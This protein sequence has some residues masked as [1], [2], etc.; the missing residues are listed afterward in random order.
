MPKIVVSYRREDSEAIAGRIRDRLVGHYSPESVFMDIDSIPYGVDFREQIQ[1]ALRS[2]DIL[3]AVIGPK[4]TGAARGRRARIREESDPVRI[5][6]ERALESGITLVPILVNGAKMPKAAD[7]PDSLRD[8]SYRNAA[9][10]DAG[11]D[12]HQHVDRLIRSMDQILAV[13]PASGSASTAL[14]AQISPAPAAVVNTVL[15]SDSGNRSA[16]SPKPAAETAPE[17]RVGDEATAVGGPHEGETVAADIIITSR[18]IRAPRRWVMALAI[19]AAICMPLLGGGYFYL[20]SVDLKWPMASPTSEPPKGPGSPL[21]VAAIDTSCKPNGAAAFYDDFKTPEGGWGQ[22]SEANFFKDGRMVLQPKINEFEKWIYFPLLFKDAVICSEVIS[23]SEIKNPDQDVAGGIIFWA[24]DIGNYYVAEIHAN[25]SYSIWRRVS[26]K[27]VSVVPRT[28]APEL[29]EGPNAVNQLKVST[30]RNRAALFANGTKLV[31]FWGQPP[32]RGGAVGLFGQSEK[33]A[34]N[35]WKFSSISVTEGTKESLPSAR[36]LYSAET[37]SFLSACKENGTA[38]FFDDFSSPDPGWGAS[39]DNRT[40]KDGRMLLK[41]SAKSFASWIFL[42]MIFKSGIVCADIKSPAQI[43]NLGSFSEGGVIFWASD[44]NNYYLA[45]LFPDATFKVSRRIDGRWATVL[46]RAQA[47][48][49]QSGE[50]AVN[51]LKITFGNDSAILTVNSSEVAELRRAQPPELGGA[52]GL[53]G[54]SEEEIENEWSFHNIAVMENNQPP[55]ASAQSTSSASDANP[56]KSAAPAAFFDNFTAPDPGWGPSSTSAYFDSGQMVL[57]PKPNSSQ[58]WIYSPMVFQNATICSQ[59][60][61]PTK[62]NKSDDLAAGGL[63]FWAED[64]DNYYQAKIFT[65]GTYS[66]SRRLAGSWISVVRRTKADNVR[67]DPD[68]INQLTVTTEGSI[69]TLTVNGVKLV[70][71]WGQPPSKG[72]AV[73]MFAQ[74][75]ADY[76]NEWRFSSIA[77]VEH[78]QQQPSYPYAAQAASSVCKKASSPVFFDNFTSP[79]P[80]WGPAGPA[81]FFKD[82][83]MVLKPEVAISW[84]LEPLIFSQATI[85]SE[86]KLPTQLEQAGK[87]DAG[88]IIFWAA[89]YKNYYVAFINLDGTYAVFRKIDGE[90]APVVPNTPAEAIHQGADAVNRLKVVLDHS[91]ATIVIN[92]ATVIEFRGQPPATGGAVGLYA[93]TGAGSDIEWR[94]TSLVVTD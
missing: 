46:P 74:S 8:L 28:P 19:G 51:R 39:N 12:F 75:E 56:C 38:A 88:G 60:Q 11:R 91:T 65:D 45:A 82:G 2:T 89:D 94:F 59:I 10:V 44:Y 25:R 69:G 64:S 61:S 87:K 16:P 4:W 58:S 79:D 30:G 77:V 52:V 49:I 43:K 92:D 57:K 54:Q 22:S 41:P 55:S 29:R 72:G 23:P 71:I 5:E 63:V 34:S 24:M 42:P 18:P 78:K 20:Q 50:N 90:W 48:D 26:G 9:V 76:Q 62:I 14:T 7:L 70:D 33:D 53:Y 73:G 47:P 1:D 27:W 37:T 32:G 40:F 6:I 21:S 36:A 67:P 66:V 35:E 31:D 13:T 81:R 85:C 93:Q 84:I 86:F 15:K 17:A 3:V 80:G 83:Q 68:A